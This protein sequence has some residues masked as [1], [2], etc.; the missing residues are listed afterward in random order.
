MATIP[1]TL[2]TYILCAALIIYHTSALPCKAP[3]GSGEPMRDLLFGTASA[4][5]T[6]SHI[7]CH[8]T[9]YAEYSGY[10]ETTSLRSDLGSPTIFYDSVCSVP[11]FRAPVGRSAEEFLRESQSHGWPSFRPSEMFKENVIIHQGG[12]LESVCGTHLGHNL[13]DAQ[14]DRF[15]VDLVCIAGQ[16]PSSSKV[17][18]HTSAP[19][20]TSQSSASTATEAMSNSSTT[21]A[22]GL[23]DKQ[24][25]ATPQSAATP[26]QGTYFVHLGY[27]SLSLLLMAAW[28]PI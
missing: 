26:L 3:D 14:G 28:G 20:A 7:C 25:A 9:Y 19:I 17:Q 12:R 4:W 10:W 18:A 22:S 15:C 13:P 1:P 5:D 24:L 11:L 8:N 16:P 2:K 21:T 6:A 23:R 27:F